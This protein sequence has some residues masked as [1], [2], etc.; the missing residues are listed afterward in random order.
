MKTEGSLPHSLVTAT[1][2]CPKQA[3]PSPSPHSHF[4]KI[5]LNIIL[6]STPGCHKWS[7]SSGS[8]TKTL[9]TPLLSSYALHAPPISFFSI[10]SSEQYWVRST[11]HEAPHYVVLS[12]PLLPF[13]RVSISLEA[14]NYCPCIQSNSAGFSFVNTGK[15][16]HLKHVRRH[17]ER[18]LVKDVH[19]RSVASRNWLKC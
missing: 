19:H 16:V 5:H 6:P 1:C 13:Y 3:G 17:F 12:T 10:L 9:Y 18:N 8:P 15:Q 14:P 11:D 4:L 2:P 7:Y